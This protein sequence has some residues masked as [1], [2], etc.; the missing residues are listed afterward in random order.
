MPLHLLL[1]SL[2][3]L[4]FFKTIAQNRDETVVFQAGEEGYKCFR[5]PAIVKTKT[6]ELLAFCEAR[7]QSCS[8]HGDVRI[9][10]KRS[11]DNGI[12][13]GKM[14]VVAENG[15]YQAGNPAPVFDFKDKKYKNGRLFL[16]YNTGIGSEQEVR[17]GKTKRE[18]WYKI[19]NDAGKTWSN[20]TNITQFVSKT[21]EDWRSYANTPGHALQLTKGRHTGRLFIAANHSAGAPQDSF[22]D[23]KAH[24][25][26]SDDNGKT[27]QVTPNIDYAGSNE[28]TAAELSKGG[29]LMNIRN[30]S[31][32]SKHRI[33][34]YSQSGGTQWDNVYI[35]KQLP[36][37]VC[38]GSMINFK[39]P[40]GKNF[41]LF[42]NL[43]NQTK[44]EHLTLKYSDNDG[45]TWY[46]GKVICEWSAA[47][48]DIVVQQNNTIGIL[49]EKDGY[50]KIV[51]Q[52]VGFKTIFKNKTY[53]N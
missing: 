2:T 13:W 39:T 23:Y 50:E 40:T 33:L 48:S 19:S 25:F 16:F 22:K 14:S 4:C 5:I 35:E 42:T 15:D 26:Y 17:E 53:K 27:W 24:G 44:R 30:Q 6:G 51:Y 21:T 34:A 45:K 43:D 32:D 38:E 12:T 41:I 37:P 20:A 52:R 28:S 1:S 47:Y 49:Y 10:V 31:G 3:I 36:D 11:A 9:V 29:I 8:D 46:L 18:I 7:R